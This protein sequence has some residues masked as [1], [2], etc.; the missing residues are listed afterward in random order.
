MTADFA[1]AIENLKQRFL[2]RSA[3][4]LHLLVDFQTGQN[5]DVE[6][7]KYIVHRLAGTAATLGFAD[8]S[9]AAA[10]LEVLWRAYGDIDGECL[11]ALIA[12]VRKLGAP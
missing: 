4:E 10:R 6:G 9:T 2:D 5:A 1:A 3:E 12:E 8:V 7:L 11:E